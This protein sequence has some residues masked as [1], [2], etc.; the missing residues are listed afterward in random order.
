MRLGVN[1]LPVIQLPLKNQAP[2]KQD[3]KALAIT[4]FA[5]AGNR[6]VMVFGIFKQAGTVKAGSGRCRAEA[7]PTRHYSCRSSAL[8]FPSITTAPDFGFFSFISK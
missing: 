6:K 5:L 3:A 7:H 1:Q 4:T 8:K 2:E